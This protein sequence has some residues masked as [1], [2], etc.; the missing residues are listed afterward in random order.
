MAVSTAAD[1]WNGRDMPR[2]DY[3]LAVAQVTD[4]AAAI[5]RAKSWAKSLD[6]IPADSFLR[7]TINGVPRCFP[8]ETSDAS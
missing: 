7:V 8:L 5:E 2:F 4:E 1:I 6:Q 3:C